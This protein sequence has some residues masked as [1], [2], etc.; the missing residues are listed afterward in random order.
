MV[1][2]WWV[3]CCPFTLASMISLCPPLKNMPPW[4]SHPVG[5]SH[6]DTEVC[7]V[8]GKLDGQLRLDCDE[9]CHRLPHIIFIEIHLNCECSPQLFSQIHFLVYICQCK[10]FE[11]IVL[12]LCFFLPTTPRFSIRIQLPVPDA[13]WHRGSFGISEIQ[14]NGDCTFGGSL[15]L[16][17]VAYNGPFAGKVKFM[18]T[19]Q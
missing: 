8:K 5:N 2:V 4:T 15:F 17:D 7:D 14:M 19:H 18:R 12:F 10:P 11:C 9:V 6:N 1:M 16:F 13:K 3:W